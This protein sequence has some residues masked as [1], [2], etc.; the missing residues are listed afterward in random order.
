LKQA[1]RLPYSA[2]LW[3]SYVRQ[4]FPERRLAFAYEAGP[5]QLPGFNKTSIQADE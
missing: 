5:T 3:L 2:A 1:L 4:H